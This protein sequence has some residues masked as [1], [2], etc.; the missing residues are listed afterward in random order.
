MEPTV[1]GMVSLIERLRKTLPFTSPEARP[2][3]REAE[4]KTVVALDLW[5]QGE[6]VIVASLMT[7][8]CI[9]LLDGCMLTNRT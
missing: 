8:I 5:S 7:D 2:F 1:A 4:K 6:R 3:Y 9:M